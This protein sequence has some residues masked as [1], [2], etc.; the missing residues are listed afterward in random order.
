MGTLETHTK[1]RR[2]CLQGAL[3]FLGFDDFAMESGTLPHQTSMDVLGS[4]GWASRGKVLVVG[5]PL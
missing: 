4:Q 2:A 1:D 5:P 3:G